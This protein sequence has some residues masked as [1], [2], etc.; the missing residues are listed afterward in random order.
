MIRFKQTYPWNFSCKPTFQLFQ[1]PRIREWWR[2]MGYFLIAQNLADECC[3]SRL[4]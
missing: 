1:Q 2:I 3:V 4:Y